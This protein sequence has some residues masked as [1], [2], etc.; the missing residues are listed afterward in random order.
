MRRRCG[1]RRRGGR[2]CATASPAPPSRTGVR[3]TPKSSAGS[4]RPPTC[5][6]IIHALEESAGLAA[7]RHSHVW[8]CQLDERR[9]GEGAFVEPGVWDDESWL[10]YGEIAE[11]QDVEVTPARP[12]RALAP[13]IAPQ[14]GLE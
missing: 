7:A 6:E 12:S 9:Q 4:P 10:V 3:Q 14:A 11:E 13:P 8:P 5:S 2:P 1:P